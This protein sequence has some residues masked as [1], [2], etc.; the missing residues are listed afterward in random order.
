MSV[1]DTLTSQNATLIRD[2]VRAAAS[3]SALE[4]GIVQA[5]RLCGYTV[6]E[7]SA[8]SGLPVDE[9]RALLN[10]PL[11]REDLASLLASK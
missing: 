4:R 6:D 11:D 7:V 1:L 3:R 8:A 9:I 5:V 2:E 10:R